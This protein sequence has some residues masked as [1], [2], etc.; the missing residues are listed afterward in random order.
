MLSMALPAPA[1]LEAAEEARL[2]RAARLGNRDAARRIYEVHV[3]RIYR[4]VRALV[5]SDAEAEDATQDAFVD[6]LAHLDRYEARPG[7]RFAA[8]L[9]TL[10]L[11]RARKRRVA[12]ARTRPAGPEELAPLLD[13]ARGGQGGDEDALLRRRALLAALAE[14]PERDRRVVALF[15]GAELTAEEVAHAT[16]L[17][18]AAVRKICERRRRELLARLGGG[19]P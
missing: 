18:P 5:G 8:W 4:T 19:G 16:G 15:H 3:A 6:A 9:A 10:A 11:N 13:A 7:V 12:S 1:P 2:V 17:S 14:L